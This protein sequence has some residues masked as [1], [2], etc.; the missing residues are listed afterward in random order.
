RD[1]VVS[2]FNRD[3]PFDRFVIEQLA[4]DLLPFEGEAQQHDQLIAT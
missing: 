3:K 2:A 1:Y 4:G